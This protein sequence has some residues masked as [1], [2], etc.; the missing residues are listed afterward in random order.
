MAVCPTEN[1]LITTSKFTYDIL[2]KKYIKKKRK[3]ILYRATYALIRILEMLCG[4][5]SKKEE[6]HFF[7]ISRVFYFQV[8]KIYNFPKNNK[9]LD[10]F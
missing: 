5:K 6:Q 3:I 1:K 2:P 8:P 9:S 4:V 10:I 7:Y